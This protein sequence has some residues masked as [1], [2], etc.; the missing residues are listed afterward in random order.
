MNNIKEVKRF[1]SEQI[2]LEEDNSYVE[3]NGN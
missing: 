3:E 1:L 2:P